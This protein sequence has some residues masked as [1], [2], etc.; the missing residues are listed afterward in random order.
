[1]LQD[2]FLKLWRKPEALSA[3]KC[4]DAWM[5]RVIRN[6]CIDRSRALGP[7][8]GEVDESLLSNR[9]SPLREVEARDHFTK[10]IALLRG[11]PEQYRIVLQL[12]HIEEKTVAEIAEHLELT[13]NNV[14]VCL[15]RARTLLKQRYQEKHHGT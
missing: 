5:T 9:P 15:S 2:V 4:P 10:T 11:L 13:P 8:Q 7:V 3:A 14:R 12:R 1:M 6:A